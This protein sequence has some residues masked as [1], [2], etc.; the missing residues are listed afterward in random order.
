MNIAEYAKYAWFSDL[1]YVEWSDSNTATKEEMIAASKAAQ[2]TPEMLG[3]KIFSTDK[4]N[5]SVL[6]FSP[7]DESGFKASLYGNGTEKILAIC[8]T[9]PFVPDLTQADLAEIGIFGLAAG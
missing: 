6:S 1:S 4:N 8:G 7:N 9:E 2:R 3:E 5:Y